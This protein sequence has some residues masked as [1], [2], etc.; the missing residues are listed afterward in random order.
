MLTSKSKNQDVKAV[1]N[2]KLE[3]II[4]E[5]L[6]PKKRPK[7]EIIKKERK[8]KCKIKRYILVLIHIV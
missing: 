5:P 8:G 4:D 3:A 7:N 2:I 1:T 6:R